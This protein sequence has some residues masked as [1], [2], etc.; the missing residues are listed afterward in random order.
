MREGRVDDKIKEKV[1]A[2]FEN[3]HEHRI[4]IIMNYDPDA[5]IS[6]VDKTRRIF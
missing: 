1:D 6:K 2:A 5:S 4:M 3:Q